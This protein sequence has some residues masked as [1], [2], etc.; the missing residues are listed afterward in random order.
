MFA[1]SHGYF[2]YSTVEQ[3][4]RRSNE[5]SFHFH[6]HLTI[7]C[8]YCISLD[9]MCHSQ[10]ILLLA[11]LV[12]TTLRTVTA[13][14]L[15]F[16]DINILVVTDVHSWVASRV[17]HEPEYNADYGH[18]LSLYQLLKHQHAEN[19]LFFVMNGDFMDGTGLSTYPPKYLA[20]ILLRMP[21]NALNIGNHEL[22]QNSTVE[23]IRD[24]FVQHWNGRYLTSNVLLESTHRPIGSRYT[25]IKGN[26]SSLL[27]FGFLYNMSENCG[28]SIVE[29]VGQV[30]QTDWFRMALLTETYDAIL[31]LAH[32]DFQDDLV[33][34]ICDAIRV[35]LSKPITIQFITGH[36]HIRAFTAVDEASTSFEA[37]HYL[38]TVGFISFPKLTKEFIGVNVTNQFQHVFIK[39]NTD[40]F[41]NI[42]QVDSLE[43][44][45]GLEL[46]Q[47]I[48][49]TRKDMGLFDVLGCSPRL[50]DVDQGLDQQDS[51]WN[52]Y[53][54]KVVAATYLQS[55]IKSIFLQS[56][57]AFR[58]SF[59]KGEVNIDDLTSV[60]PFNDTVFS[61]DTA[62]EGRILLMLLGGQPNQVGPDASYGLPSI[63]SSL[64]H[65]N[66]SSFYH[67]YTV[68]FD[69]P[70]IVQNL[71]SLTNT[72][73]TATRQYADNGME[74]T[75]TTLWTNY[76][77]SNWKCQASVY[78]R[79]VVVLWSFVPGAILLSG[80]L[81]LALYFINV[82]KRRYGFE[83]VNSVQDSFGDKG[84][85]SRIVVN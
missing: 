73:I 5:D 85:H 24:H 72:T 14:I 75:T 61:L 20:P 76:I 12:T 84:I 30:V 2:R 31:V 21:W 35:I 22:Y 77:D 29:P 34:V 48:L 37:G 67:V 11:L 25:V 42:L 40:T 41:K 17:R 56:T 49:S 4:S 69:L 44:I 60:T 38:D 50:Y 45:E 58:S 36:S 28:A 26:Q 74:M 71:E 43:T 46:S 78:D 64:F 59:F 47:F 3:S 81:L 62:I 79:T 1:M 16:N 10:L 27:T 23:Y 70:G 82:R 33:K 39:A 6:R 55:S 13:S 52:L 53:L 66:A 65:V 19:D 80:I 8:M 15:P 18:V 57:G 7:K 51:L 83:A 54:T 32:M 63:G 9:T 68:W